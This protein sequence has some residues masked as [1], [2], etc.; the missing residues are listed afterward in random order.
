MVLFAKILLFHKNPRFLK[1]KITKFRGVC[2]C[3]ITFFL[4]L[5]GILSHDKVL[6]DIGKVMAIALCSDAAI[7]NL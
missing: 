6:N 3:F 2:G 4:F 5:D 7:W 1:E